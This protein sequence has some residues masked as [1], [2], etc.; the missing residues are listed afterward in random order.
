MVHVRTGAQVVT[1]RRKP[2]LCLCTTL[3]IV[4]PSHGLCVMLA[5][6]KTAFQHLALNNQ[7][8]P[9]SI[10]AYYATHKEGVHGSHVNE[11]S[12][13]LLIFEPHT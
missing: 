3:N 13:T 9:T 8:Q 1:P 10:Y 2:A 5:Q 4:V 12:L 6:L 11:F 7:I